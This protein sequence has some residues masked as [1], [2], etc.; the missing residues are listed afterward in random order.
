MGKH[1]FDATSNNE[2]SSKK[3]QQLLSGE[4]PNFLERL[5]NVCSCGSVK[6]CKLFLLTYFSSLFVLIW[7][8]SFVLC[9]AGDTN[10]FVKQ[11]NKL[12]A[13]IPAPPAFASEF[14]PK[15]VALGLHPAAQSSKSAHVTAGMISITDITVR[16]NAMDW[17]V[18]KNGGL[19]A[20]MCTEFSQPDVNPAALMRVSDLLSCKTEFVLSHGWVFLMCFS[21]LILSLS[22]KIGSFMYTGK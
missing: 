17:L 11:A 22:F 14:P 10:P 13:S 18:G 3:N 9:L 20:I 21:V 8:N 5:F 1:G 7:G 19:N 2:A 15:D 6:A 16:G 12:L 4:H